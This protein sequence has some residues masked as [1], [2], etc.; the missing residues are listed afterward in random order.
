[1]VINKGVGSEAREGALEGKVGD[2][3][4]SRPLVEERVVAPSDSGIHKSVQDVKSRFVPIYRSKL[5]DREW[6]NAGMLALVIAG[7]STLALQKGI[8]DAGFLS[9][10]VTPMGGDIVFLH[11]IG[12]EDIWQVFTDAIQFFGMLFNNIHK[13]S[14]T[15]VRYK[16]G[17]W[18]HV[19][20]V[21]AHARNDNFFR[22]CVMNNGRFIRG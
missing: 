19:Y 21:P 13:W 3:L 16:R 18:L 4:H 22:L 9:I 20:G 2:K 12:G 14:V 11:S 6:D 17:A 8:E 1:M 10:V 15:Y 5:E 7:D